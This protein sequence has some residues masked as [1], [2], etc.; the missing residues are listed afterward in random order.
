MADRQL[1]LLEPDVINLVAVCWRCGETVAVIPIAQGESWGAA[2]KWSYIAQKA[3]DRER[4][5]EEGEI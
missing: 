3:H 5:P 4:H 1:N 2:E